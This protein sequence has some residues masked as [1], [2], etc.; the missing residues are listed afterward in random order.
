MHRD[1]HYLVL[2]SMSVQIFVREI[3]FITG[4]TIYTMHGNVDE[5]YSKQGYKKTF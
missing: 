5:I 4:Y 1:V 2:E 3:F